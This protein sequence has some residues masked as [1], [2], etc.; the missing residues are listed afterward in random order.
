[1][2]CEENTG[3]LVF[4]KHETDTKD[5]SKNSKRVLLHVL[6]E[7]NLGNFYPKTSGGVNRTHSSMLFW[8]Q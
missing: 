6:G 5:N 3:K 7:Y 2:I 1:M 4:G 8:S